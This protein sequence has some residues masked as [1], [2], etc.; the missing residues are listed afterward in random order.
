[1]EVTKIK[2]HDNIKLFL[3][4]PSDTIKIII[5][6]FW[7]IK[8]MSECNSLFRY[9]KISKVYPHRYLTTVLRS[10]TGLTISVT[11]ISKFVFPDVVFI[12]SSR[13]FMNYGRDY[14]VWWTSPNCLNDCSLLSSFMV[15]PLWFVIFTLMDYSIIILLFWASMWSRNTVLEILD[16]VLSI[17]TYEK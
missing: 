7:W 1:M 14:R 10:L 5:F 9:W 4:L 17:S 3:S 11:L 16:N 8:Y 12:F 2:L 15:S 6:K 13:P